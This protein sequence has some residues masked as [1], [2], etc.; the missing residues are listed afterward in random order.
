MKIL[1]PRASFLIQNME[2]YMFIL[3][4]IVIIL[5]QITKKIAFE[6]IRTQGSKVIIENFF[7]LLYVENSG[8]AFGIFKD[9]KI[10][11]IIVT[12]LVLSF[13]ITYTYKNY[14]N[15]NVIEKLSLSLIFA[16]AVGNFIDRIARGYVID[17]LSFKFAN[18]YFPVF[19]IADIAVVVGT[20]LLM[21]I[22][23]ASGDKI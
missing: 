23:V 3:S 10:F 9:K 17:F 6:T 20:G 7:E 13:I 5:D 2:G 21:Y 12:L 4:I 18:Y 11:F 14:K 19:N 15:M 22:I 8:A 16:G 1:R